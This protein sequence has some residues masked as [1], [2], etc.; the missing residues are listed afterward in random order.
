MQNILVI[1][2]A[3]EL[4]QFLA[5]VFAELENR[6]HSFY[7]LLNKNLGPQL[8][9]NFNLFLFLTLLPFLT[10]YYL[11]IL[12]KIKQKKKIKIVICLNWNEKIM[13]T[14]LGRIFRLKVVWLE[15]PEIVYKDKPVILIWF[16]RFFSRW[17]EIITFICFS[18]TQLNNL[19]IKKSK[20]RIVLPGIKPSPYKHQDTIFSNLAKSPLSNFSRKYFT[21][22]TVSELKQPNQ[23]ENLF[24]AVRKCLTVI[25]NLQIIIVG[26]GV[27]RKNLIWLAKKMEI[28]NIVWFVGEPSR[29]GQAMYL[30]KWLKSFD[31]FVITSEDSSL[32]NLGIVLKAMAIGLPIVGPRNKGFEDIVLDGKTGLLV[33]ANNSEALT[34]EII[35]IEQ[36]GRLRRKLGK[37]GV[38]LV[39]K[40]FRIERTVRELEEIF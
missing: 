12:F 17:A 32:S 5:D 19:G 8:S 20:I 40:S 6:G 24:R 39:E 11:F 1:N 30:R 3:K 38:E 23:I 36:D 22:G 37:N 34:K 7:W 13:F 35:K 2:S 26:D 9:N 27:E 29:G 16:Y 31:I 4:S 10:G 28:N 33:E 21:I 15:Y 14:F 18:K 25:P